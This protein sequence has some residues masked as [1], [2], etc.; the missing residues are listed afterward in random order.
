[1]VQV[2]LRGTGYVEVTID[3]GQTV[4]LGCSMIF[5]DQVF[6]PIRYVWRLAGR[7]DTL[8]RDA[9][10]MVTPDSDVSYQCV[11]SA[12]N[13]EDR[14]I[15]EKGIIMITVRGTYIYIYLLWYSI[16]KC[17]YYIYKRIASP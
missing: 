11:A 13:L 2:S 5:T 9:T 17:I 4:A 1:M 3:K 10:Y 16:V 7:F 8:S 6:L 14:T 12:R 15:R